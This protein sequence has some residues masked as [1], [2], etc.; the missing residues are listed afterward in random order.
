MVMSRTTTSV[1][2]SSGRPPV[3]V[4]ASSRPPV[5]VSASSHPSASTTPSGPPTPAASPSPVL[6][7]QIAARMVQS[8][9]RSAATL[10][11]SPGDSPSSSAASSHIPA[12]GSA[13][14]M[15]LPYC[16]SGIFSR[17]AACVYLRICRPAS[18]SPA[19][20][21]VHICPS[22][23]GLTCFYWCISQF[24]ATFDA[25]AFAKA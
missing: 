3:T 14:G 1:T 24:L 16:S 23:V 9:L 10:G 8:L 17:L 4:S 11:D 18:L 7:D 22:P 25:V 13:S 2:T 21:R 15:S 12:A 5:S 19:G 20:Y 6:L